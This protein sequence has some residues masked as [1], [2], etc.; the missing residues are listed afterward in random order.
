[1]DTRKAWRN[2]EKE[3]IN[4]NDIHLLCLGQTRTGKT[5]KMYYLEKK[6]LEKGKTIVHFDSG[7]SSEILPLC[8]FGVPINV[9]TPDGLTCTIEGATVPIT[10]ASV[11]FPQ[12]MW[13][14]IKKGAINIF[15]FRR[16]FREQ[17]DVSK[18]GANLMRGL[19]D[20]VYDEYPLPHPI[21]V[22]IDEFAQVCPSEKLME[23]TYQK[24][25]ASRFSLALKTIGSQ[26]ICISGYDQA[27][28]DIYPNARRQFPMLLVCRSPGFTRDSGISDR[29]APGFSSL[30]VH[31][32]IFIFPWKNWDCVFNF[33]L[34]KTPENI[35]VKYSGQFTGK[36]EAN[37]QPEIEDDMVLP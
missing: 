23:N 10:Y 7:K 28:R 25:M 19:V 13:K 33:P 36:A 32:G 16:Y 21:A 35:T 12:E 11:P 1:M 20:A 14:H 17:T 5:Q 8:E 9:I 6:Q 27:W 26:Q 31:Q 24:K 15:T 29:Y 30:R 3:Y 34:F 22:H 4:R 2:I 37:R 18:Y